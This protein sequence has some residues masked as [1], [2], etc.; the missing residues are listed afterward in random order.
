METPASSSSLLKIYLQ[1]VLVPAV[2]HAAEL[3]NGMVNGALEATSAPGM[4]SHITKLL[5]TAALVVVGLDFAFGWAEPLAANK[6]DKTNSAKNLADKLMLPNDLN[7]FKLCFYLLF[8][9]LFV[10]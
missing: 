10:N 7:F 5:C 8:L 6:S 1:P 2:G 4:I 3:L 9:K